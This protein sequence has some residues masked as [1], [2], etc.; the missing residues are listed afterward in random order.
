MA[1]LLRTLLATAL[2]TALVPAIA[3]AQPEPL[4]DAAPSGTRFEE[5]VTSSNPRVARTAQNAQFY[6]YETRDGTTVRVAISEGY[7]GELSQSVAHSYVEFL[8]DLEHGPELAQL[9]IYIAPLDE[10]QHECGGADGTLACYDST[11]RIMVVPGE[12]FRT[13]S[14]VTTS[15]VVAHEYGHHIAAMRSNAPFSAFATGPKYWSS[16]QLVCERSSNGLLAP[17]NEAEQY[18]SNP[19]E[20]WAETYAQLKYPGVSWQ[21]TPILKPDEAAFA[22]ARRD[23]G[24]PWRGQ[25]TKVF[26]GSFGRGGSSAKRFSFDLTLDGALSM[27]LTGPRA[28][29]YDLVI[30]SNGRSEGRTSRP[31]SR[32]RVSYPAACREDQ[33]ERVTVA[34]KRVKGKG[35]FTLRVSYAG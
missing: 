5:R 8:G 26:K 4:V 16:Y 34:V 22:A 10:V 30:S 17:G 20:G 6:G 13:T 21:Y 3:H 19:G 28:A 15:Y 23:V 12:S 33:L 1:R 24:S 14:G 32:D 18:L 2:V 7:G 29:N 31:G 9:S 11:T 27:R 25:A 35:P